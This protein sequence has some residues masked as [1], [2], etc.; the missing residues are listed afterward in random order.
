[1]FLVNKL[2]AHENKIQQMHGHNN[3]GKLI[4]YG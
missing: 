3:F 4:R 1:M 2:L